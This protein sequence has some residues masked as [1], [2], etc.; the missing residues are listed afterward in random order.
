MSRHRHDQHGHD[1]HGHDDALEARVLELLLDGDAQRELERLRADPAATE[2]VARLESFLGLCRSELAP[3][4]ADAG[5]DA[6]AQAVLASTTRE[7]LD[8]RG[9]L[10]LVRGFVARRLRSSMWL[11]VAAASLLV[12]VA[13]LPVVAWYAFQ[14]RERGFAIDFARPAQESPVAP[15]VAEP[16][17]DLEGTAGTA[18]LDDLLGAGPWGTRSATVQNN[19]RR[20]RYWLAAGDAPRA[21]ARPTTAVGALLEERAERLQRYEAGEPGAARLEDPS[22]YAEPLERVLAVELL[23]D[24]CVLTGNL[25]AHLERGLHSLNAIDE[26]PVARLAEAALERAAAYGWPGARA[27]VE[28]VDAPYGARWRDRLRAALDAEAERD[29]AV[30]AW[31]AADDER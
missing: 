22:A 21:G 4:G 27:V 31:L 15:D 18:E 23:L 7:D 20:A 1:E 30:R 24:E 6:L 2:T 16:E 17:R 13:A 8:W 12:H 19:L 26:G 29:P 9:D 25:P 11:R 28:P 5:A 3:V 10:R 14:P